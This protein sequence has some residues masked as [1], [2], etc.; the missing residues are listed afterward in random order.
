[1]LESSSFMVDIFDDR[2]AEM[3]LLIPM[4]VSVLKRLLCNATLYLNMTWND[5]SPYLPCSSTMWSVCQHKSGYALFPLLPSWYGIPAGLCKI[6]KSI[7]I[8]C[9]NGYYSNHVTANWMIPALIRIDKRILLFAFFSSCRDKS[10]TA[11]VYHLTTNLL[12]L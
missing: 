9:Q 4:G 1:M 5:S 10:Y 12:K 11:F 8:P 6:S 2:S 7:I 3:M